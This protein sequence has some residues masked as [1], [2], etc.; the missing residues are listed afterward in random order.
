MQKT[1][2]KNP[3]RMTKMNGTLCVRVPQMKLVKAVKVV[4]KVRTVRSRI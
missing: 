4:E 2:T 3:R 1:K